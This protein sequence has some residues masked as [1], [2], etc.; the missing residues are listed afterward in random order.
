MDQYTR[1]MV[2]RN[3]DQF[4]IILRKPKN[5]KLILKIFEC[6]FCVIFGLFISLDLISIGLEIIVKSGVIPLPILKAIIG[7][8]MIIVGVLFCKY[9]IIKPIKILI[10]TIST[11]FD[12]GYH[13]WKEP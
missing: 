10:K 7:I 13:G 11:A 12:E 8:G 1:L 4:I 5:E 2:K 6:M 3:I 9:S